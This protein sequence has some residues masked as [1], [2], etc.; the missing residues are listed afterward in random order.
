VT[1][2]GGSTEHVFEGK[3]DG[4]TI[5]G[6]VYTRSPQESFDDTK[7]EYTA[8]FHTAVQPNSLCQEKGTGRCVHG[9]A[10]VVV[11]AVVNGPAHG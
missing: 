6:K 5:S 8:T 11:W 9:V 10:M 3:Q 7:Y 4:H 1:P 2:S